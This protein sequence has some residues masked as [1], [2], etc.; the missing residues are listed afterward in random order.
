MNLWNLGA[1]L[2]IGGL[3]AIGFYKI[4]IV[5]I[6]AWT[7]GDAARSL[8]ISEGFKSI[9]DANADLLGTYHDN[10]TALLNA[11][12]QYQQTTNTAI[13]QIA[14]DVR[15]LDAATR[16]AFDLTPVRPQF[17]PKE[18]LEQRTPGA[19]P[20]TTVD[21]D[22]DTPVDRPPINP[23]VDRSLTPT[24]RAKSI[25]GIVSGEYIVSPSQPVRKPSKP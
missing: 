4:A 12:S 8:A 20:V 18:K 21:D 7:K 10:H 5:L 9:T 11:L 22:K 2:G 13:A 23:K 16:T 19:R 1:S 24:Q 15:A 14:G 3:I 25:G 6:N 17:I